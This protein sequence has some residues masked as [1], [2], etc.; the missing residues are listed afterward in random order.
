MHRQ[1]F[2]YSTLGNHGRRHPWWSRASNRGDARPARRLT[3]PADYPSLP[4]AIGELEPLSHE[5]MGLS[6]TSFMPLPVVAPDVAG[7]YRI[8]KDEQL[9][10]VGESRSLRSR[11]STHSKDVRFMNCE[12][13]YHCM[14]NALPHN[15]KEREV[16]L[17]GSFLLHSKQPPFFQYQGQPPPASE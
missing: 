13:S 2:G 12:V 6:W 14:P 4:V 10:Y 16:D 8:A 9:L 11:L 17:I 15:L 7:V 3:T 1:E 5:W